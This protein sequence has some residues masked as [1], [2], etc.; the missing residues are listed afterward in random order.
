MTDLPWEGI[1]ELP[2]GEFQPTPSYNPDTDTL[3]LFIADEDYKRER[4]DRYLTVYK[5]LESGKV[6]GCHIKNIVSS[7][8]KDVEAMHLGVKSEDVTLSL[9]LSTIPIAAGDEVPTLV[10][11]ELVRPLSPF[12]EHVRLPELLA[13]AN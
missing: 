10:Y 1:T 5:S 12:G 2:R 4:V 7:L 6:I 13:Q 8:L 9:V 3:T 11:Q